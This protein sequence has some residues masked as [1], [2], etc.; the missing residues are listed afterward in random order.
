[1]RQ[2]S[3]HHRAAAVALFAGLLFTGA[4]HAQ[5][6]TIQHSETTPGGDRLYDTVRIGPAQDEYSGNGFRV[7]TWKDLEAVNETLLD[8]I[9]YAYDIHPK[10]VKNA[11]AWADQKHFDL[12]IHYRLTGEIDDA[13]CKLMVRQIL[14]DRFGLAANGGGVHQQ[15]Y[16]LHVEPTGPK[17]VAS[18]ASPGSLPAI[19]LPKP[20][21]LHAHNTS[22]ADLAT[23]LQRDV[24]DRAVVD[25]TGV[26]G[27][28]DFDILWSATPAQANGQAGPAKKAPVSSLED[29]LKQQLGLRLDEAKTPPS[30]LIIEH[31]QM[32]AGL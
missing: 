10:L 30:D 17:L 16:A 18:L 6:A 19:N 20:G 7:R 26:T 9:A 5:Q 15:A 1:M 3:K 22:V 27:R 25:E 4:G 21:T 14:Q 23:T 11:P 24:L 31:V 13:A 32:P 8:M 2:V 28:W 29:A 12:A